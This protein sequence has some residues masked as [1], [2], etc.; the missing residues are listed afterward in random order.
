MTSL[1]KGNHYQRTKRFLDS[2]GV[3]VND[4]WLIYDRYRGP[5]AKTSQCVVLDIAEI[6]SPCLLS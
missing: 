5:C 3:P 1:Q 4:R 2:R 6:L